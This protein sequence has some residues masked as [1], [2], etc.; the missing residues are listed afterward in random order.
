MDLLKNVLKLSRDKYLHEKEKGEMGFATSVDQLQ[1]ES[2]Y[3]ADSSAVIMQE[4]AYKNSIKNL[5]LFL[6]TDINLVWSLTDKLMPENIMYNYED[7]ESKMLSNNTNIKNQVDKY[8]NY[9][10]GYYIS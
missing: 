9:Q 7:L 10:T 3:L 8:G 1:F 2:A 5:N 6:G 4:L